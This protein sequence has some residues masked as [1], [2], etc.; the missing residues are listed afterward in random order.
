MQ[1][2]GDLTIHGVKR[3]VKVPGTLELKN[4]RLL[5]TSKFAVAPADYNIEIPAL[6]RDNIAKSMEVTLAFSCDP[7]PT[8]QT[9][10]A[11]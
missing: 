6:V 2:E 5:V 7:A 4:N 8:S 1:V 11:R 9:A 10:V 3:R